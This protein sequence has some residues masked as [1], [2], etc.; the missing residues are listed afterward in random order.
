MVSDR[1]CDTLNVTKDAEILL[2]SQHM[3]L[4]HLVIDQSMRGKMNSAKV[5]P[6]AQYGF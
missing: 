5:Q 2:I 1:W 6:Q 4:N 3:T